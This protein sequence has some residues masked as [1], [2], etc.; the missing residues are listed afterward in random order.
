[1]EHKS[2]KELAVEA[3]IEY[4][5]SWNAKSNTQGAKPNEFIQTL[6]SI[7]FALDELDK[8]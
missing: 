2:N 7:Y 3:A 1:M 4:V 8:E 5:K 6:K